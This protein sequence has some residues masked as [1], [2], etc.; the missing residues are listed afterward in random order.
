[1]L[2]YTLNIPRLIPKSF[3]SEYMKA[4]VV[5]IAIRPLYV[6]PGCLLDALK[7]VD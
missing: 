6:T 1:M 4:Y 5:L 2:V 7:R 3:R